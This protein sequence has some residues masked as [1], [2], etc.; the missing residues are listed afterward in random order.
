MSAQIE[1]T[2]D[3]LVTKL[4]TELPAK[5][6]AINAEMPDDYQIGHPE[7]VTFGPRVE[8]QYP[9][10]A[11][12]P[13]S[14]ESADTSGRIHFNHAIEITSWVAEVSPEALV[15]KL[16]RYQRAVREVVLRGRQPAV[17]E[18][19]SAGYGLQHISDE[20]GE[21]FFSEEEPGGF[22]ISYVTSIFAVQQQQDLV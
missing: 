16:I 10:V 17:S 11:V 19:S 7:S 8:M 3:G 2:I 9:H 22:T 15:R 5:I 12:S 20:Y 18:F 14:T 6:D 1:A 13:S 21:L 4:A